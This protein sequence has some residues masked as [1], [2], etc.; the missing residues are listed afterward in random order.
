MCY[1]SE[2]Y[3]G[4]KLAPHCYRVVTSRIYHAG[5]PRAKPTMMRAKTKGYLKA[6]RRAKYW[7][8]WAIAA[9]MLQKL[10]V[11]RPYVDRSS[12]RRTVGDSHLLAV[13]QPFV[14]QPMCLI[15]RTL[16]LTNVLDINE[17]A[18]VP[19]VHG[20]TCVDTVNAY[21]CNCVA[22]YTGTNCQTGTQIIMK[23][24][25]IIVWSALADGFDRYDR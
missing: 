20:A 22:G 11:M 8:Q 13:A 25:F 9:D 3:N 15:I 4:D 23:V 14:P 17:C 1:E 6:R 19:C 10:T 2:M 16:C 18:S 12:L 7:A 24:Y 21:T 5:E